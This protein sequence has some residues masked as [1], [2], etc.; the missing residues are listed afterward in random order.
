MAVD[1]EPE[2]L[3]I[4]SEWFSMN[5]FEI[6]TFDDSRKA[7]EELNKDRAFDVVILDFLMAPYDG[8]EVLKKIKTNEKTRTLP[9]FILSQMGEES[10]KVMAKKLGAADYLIKSEFSLKELEKRIRVLIEAKE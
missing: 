9:V 8:L 4:L 5:G 2:F 6:I 7:L 10:Y 1:D 3:K